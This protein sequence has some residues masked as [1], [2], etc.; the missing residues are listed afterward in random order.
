M[1][2]CAGATRRSKA[3]FPALVR[4]DSPSRRVGAQPSQKFAKV[5]HA[6]PMLSLGN[7]FSDDEVIEFVE[8]V[9]RFLRLPVEEKVVFT[10]EPKIDGLS[11]TLRYEGGR[12]VR[13][14]TRGDGTEGEEVTPNVRTLA[15]IPDT[16]R[17]KRLPDICEV[18]GEVY[19]TKS[20][21]VAL[22]ERQKAAGRQVF[23]N[24][25]NS[26]AGSLRQLD[27]TITASRP[28]GFFAYSWG[29]MSADAGANA[30]GHARLVRL[31]RLQDQSAD[32]SMR[33]RRRH[34]RV[35]P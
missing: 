13:G 18:R 11:C 6:V 17:G 25:R 31:L 14:A 29:E 9:R 16:L 21:F 28:L 8:R 24:P 33:L 2:H 15:D 5:R 19:M 4:T 23:A 7:A 26:A 1:T 30:I 20:A 32:A 3:L 27:P 12:L 22:N 34:A 35:P 10:A